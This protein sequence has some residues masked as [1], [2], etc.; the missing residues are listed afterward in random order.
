MCLKS[1]FTTP[2]VAA[3]S[4][5]LIGGT[6]PA[7]ADLGD[8]L[9]KLLADDGAVFDQ[10]GY[11]VAINGD[12]AIVGAFHDDNSSGSTY[13][14]DIA[15]GKQT[16]KRLADD[17]APG[18]HFGWSVAIS[19]NTAVVGA[20]FDDE[21][22]NNSGSAYL[23]D[24]TTG[25]QLFKLLPEDGA[26]TDEFGISVAISGTIAV[27]GAWRHADNGVNSGSAYLFD[28]AGISACPWDIDGDGNVGA[29]DL[30]A[31]LASWGLCKD[32]CPADFDGDGSVGASDLL[33]L[34]AN[35]GPCP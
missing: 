33:A 14:F 18:D 6:T 27:V 22:G 9:F 17:G 15:T 11:S 4:F 25:D 29:S 21:N 34:L 31:L 8:Q 16:A 7:Y 28:A 32:C 12:I 5:C 20:K 19:G 26:L 35:W 23:F 1:N 2:A 30:L 3:I 10:F 24:T 13:L